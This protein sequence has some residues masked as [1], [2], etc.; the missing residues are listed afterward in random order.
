MRILPSYMR[1][2][3]C[4][5]RV[6]VRPSS[7]DRQAYAASSSVSL[8]TATSEPSAAGVRFR[9]QPSA[10]AGSSSRVQVMPSVERQVSEPVVR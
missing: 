7:V 5:A 8:P 6:H 3:V 1:S 2:A 10:S 4:G 9:A